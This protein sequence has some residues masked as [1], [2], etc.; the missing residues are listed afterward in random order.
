MTRSPSTPSNDDR[1]R[2]DEEPDG[3]LFVA[4][5]VSTRS[6]QE[7]E[8]I[9]SNFFSRWGDVVAVRSLRDWLQRPFAFVQFKDPK[10]AQK[11]LVEA[12]KTICDGREIRVEAARV[13]VRVL[14]FFG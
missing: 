1:S 3:C 7:I 12:H 10:D 2:S 14:R 13:N 4:S 9:L 5:L 8:N 6:P 11:A